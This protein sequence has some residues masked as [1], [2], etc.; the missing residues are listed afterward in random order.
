MPQ[1]CIKA[2]FYGFAAFQLIFQFLWLQFLPSPPPTPP[3]LFKAIDV[4]V[5]EKLK[6]TGGTGLY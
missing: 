4:S 5:S 2:C 3:L 6:Y 1:K